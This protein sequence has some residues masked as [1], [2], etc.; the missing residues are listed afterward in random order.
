MK[1]TDNAY[2]LLQALFFFLA[3]YG[4]FIFHELCEYMDI[5]LRQRKK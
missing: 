1:P 2:S 5:H 3:F 4:G